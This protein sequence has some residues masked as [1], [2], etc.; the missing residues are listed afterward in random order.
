[1]TFLSKEIYET[2]VTRVSSLSVRK[3]VSSTE[4]YE[5][6]V[7][8]SVLEKTSVVG[9]MGVWWCINHLDLVHKL[10]RGVLRDYNMAIYVSFFGKPK[11]M[12]TDR[13]RGII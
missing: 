9:E 7:L 12:D 5:T 10:R 6:L 1:M 8:P 13:G 3:R 11:L 2:L 4:I